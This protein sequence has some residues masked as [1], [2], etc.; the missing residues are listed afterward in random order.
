MNRGRVREARAWSIEADADSLPDR[1]FSSIDFDEIFS[2]RFRLRLGQACI[3]GFAIDRVK[4]AAERSTR[5]IGLG[6]SLV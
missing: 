1:E 5:W 6:Y 3:E 2:N 4:D